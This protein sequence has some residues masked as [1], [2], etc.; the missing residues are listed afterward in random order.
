[1]SYFHWLNPPSSSSSAALPLRFKEEGLIPVP[2]SRKAKKKKRKMD[3]TAAKLFS[4][5]FRSQEK[6]YFFHCKYT[7]TE[8]KNTGNPLANSAPVRGH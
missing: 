4:D 2:Y 5:S 6:K 7:P 3:S 1:M 8:P